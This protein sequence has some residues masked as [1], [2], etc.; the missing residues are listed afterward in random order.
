VQ[1][2]LSVENDGT[3]G[4][5]LRA[6]TVSWATFVP[7]QKIKIVDGALYRTNAV[8]CSL[9]GYPQEEFFTAAK[10]STISINGSCVAFSSMLA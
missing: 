6:W 2:L 4:D 8:V 7:F 10:S 5:Y 1:S 3:N 9:R